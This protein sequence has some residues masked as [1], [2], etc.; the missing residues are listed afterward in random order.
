MWSMVVFR[1]HDYHHTNQRQKKRTV[2]TLDSVDAKHITCQIVV[3][4]AFPIH[5]SSF[6]LFAYWLS[7]SQISP[8]GWME[9]VIWVA[10][11]LVIGQLFFG[12]GL[13]ERNYLFRTNRFFF[14]DNIVSRE[15][16]ML[17]SGSLFIW[18]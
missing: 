10:T 7:C 5:L 18:I 4:P 15:I 8:C 14:A 6:S 13:G 16:C 9:M 3:M 2:S 12:F 11:V 17:W 1:F